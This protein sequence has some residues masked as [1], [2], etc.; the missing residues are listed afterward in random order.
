[1]AGVG[2]TTLAMAREGDL[3]RWLSS[4]GSRFHTPHHA[5][6][7]VGGVVAVLVLTADL[8]RVIGFSS[9]GVLLYYAVANLA[10][11]T[12]PA[13]YRRW[14]RAVN[15]VG[16]IGCLTLVVTLPLPS[17]L[18]GLLVLA[19]GVAGRSVVVSRRQV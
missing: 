16:L 15:V 6:L 10:A 8:R 5:E 17:L 13:E 2:R 11:F 19:I 1:V 18:V 4:V 7:A 14:P 9:F 3:P 12:Q